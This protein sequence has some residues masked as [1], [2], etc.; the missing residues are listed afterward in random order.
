[1]FCHGPGPLMHMTIHQNRITFQLNG[2][3]K[4]LGLLTIKKQFNS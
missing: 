2:D 4:I 3:I 1:M